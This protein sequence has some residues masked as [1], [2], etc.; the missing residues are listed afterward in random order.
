MSRRSLPYKLMYWLAT[1][2]R[3][4]PPIR[5]PRQSLNEV[6]SSNE[7]NKDRYIVAEAI[8]TEAWKVVCARAACGA[9]RNRAVKRVGTQNRVIEK[10]LSKIDSRGNLGLPDKIRKLF[11]WLRGWQKKRILP[12]FKPVVEF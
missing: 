6:C 2:T 1:Q 10:I 7:K 9:V 12:W 5:N 3:A 11:C 4:K 8:F